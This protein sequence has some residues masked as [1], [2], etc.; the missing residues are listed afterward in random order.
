MGDERTRLNRCGGSPPSGRARWGGSRL[1]AVGRCVDRALSGGPL[2][3][4][5]PPRGAA[6]RPAS[7]SSNHRPASSHPGQARRSREAGPCIAPPGHRRCPGCRLRG[8]GSRWAGGAST[9]QAVVGR[10]GRATGGAEPRDARRARLA[11]GAPWDRVAPRVSR[12]VEAVALGSV[13]A[14]C[15]R[16]VVRL[17]SRRGA[18]SGSASPSRYRDGGRRGPSTGRPEPRGR[19]RRCGRRALGRPASAAGAGLLGRRETQPLYEPRATS[20]EP[21]AT[22]AEPSVRAPSPWPACFSGGRRATGAA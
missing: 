17:C 1:C 19:N 5:R 21:R 20:H 22:G 7:P 6:L 10:A 14:R 15:G 2:S 13:P 11:G 12:A 9:G 3:L 8:R 4:R 16:A 18:G